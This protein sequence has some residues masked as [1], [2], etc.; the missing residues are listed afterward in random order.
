MTDKTIT[1]EKILTEITNGKYKNKG[2]DN[3]IISNSRSIVAST[4][5]GTPW[6]KDRAPPYTSENVDSIPEEGINPAAIGSDY[7]QKHIQDLKNQKR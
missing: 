5:T 1:N 7:I 4:H 6:I 2:L 3:S